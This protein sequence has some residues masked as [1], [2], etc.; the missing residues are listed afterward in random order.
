ML[1]R[2]VGIPVELTDTFDKLLLLISER[3]CRFVF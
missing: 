2:G 1:E 3:Y